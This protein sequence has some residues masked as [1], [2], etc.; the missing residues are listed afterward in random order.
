MRYPRSGHSVSFRTWC[1]TTQSSQSC[2]ARYKRS[3][4][5][6][7]SG[8]IQEPRRLELPG[9]SRC[10]TWT[11]WTPKTRQQAFGTSTQ[12][13]RL[14]FSEPKDWRTMAVADSK[15]VPNLGLMATIR[16]VRSGTLHWV[17][18]V[19]TLQLA[20]PCL[21]WSGLCHRPS[22]RMPTSTSAWTITRRMWCAWP[23]KIALRWVT[24]TPVHPKDSTAST[25][26]DE[27]RSPSE[28]RNEE[29]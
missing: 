25:P 4:K 1:G 9:L 3:M 6:T 20:K 14:R 23:S 2:K 28:A 11:P 15:P 26:R 5:G 22:S 16:C 29:N 12:P 13:T 19:W 7:R 10:A 17:A 27:Y 18:L 21:T 24:S 8:H